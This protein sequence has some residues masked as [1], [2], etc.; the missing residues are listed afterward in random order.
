[1]EITVLEFPRI[2][3]TSFLYN[4][5]FPDSWSASYVC[6]DKTSGGS[7][8]AGEHPKAVIK[9]QNTTARQAFEIV[10]FEFLIVFGIKPPA[11]WDR[12]AQLGD[13]KRRIVASNGYFSPPSDH[14][15]SVDDD[16][17]LRLQAALR[18][19]NAFQTV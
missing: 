7:R 12:K 19:G 16:T 17:T 9:S 18:K 11:G 10:M 14:D 6:S 15:G 3:D 2:L 8:R 5:S 1:M 4:T 13:R